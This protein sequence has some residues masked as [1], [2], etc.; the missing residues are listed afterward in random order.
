[1]VDLDPLSISSKAAFALAYEAGS[2]AAYLACAAATSRFACCCSAG[3]SFL[4]T[5]FVVAFWASA[6]LTFNAACV[7]GTL[8]VSGHAKLPIGGHGTAR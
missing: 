7:N 2:C 3:V 1:M 4:G 5:H 8:G 6:M